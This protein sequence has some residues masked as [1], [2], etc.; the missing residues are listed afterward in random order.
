MKKVLVILS[1]AS[2]SL[3]INFSISNQSDTAGKPKSIE[4]SI[5]QND[6]DP[7]Y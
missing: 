5:K 4:Y 2:L 7:G 3:I 6:Y 1:V